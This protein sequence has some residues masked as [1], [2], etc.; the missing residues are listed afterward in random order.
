MV[1]R[2]EKLDGTTARVKFDDGR[3][4]YVTVNEVDGA[5]YEMFLR[6]DSPEL[7]EWAS[8][9]SVLVSWLLQG[10]KVDIKDIAGEMQ[11][12]HSMGQ[13]TGFTPGGGKYHS[14]VAR[15]GSVLHDSV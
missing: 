7:H 3:R 8:I 1:E 14:M 2:P 4:V 15:I 6:T 13:H 9:T 11:G 10:R 5:P 12:I